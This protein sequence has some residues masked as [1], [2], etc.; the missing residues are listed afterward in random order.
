MMPRSV[1]SDGIQRESAIMHRF[2]VES[3]TESTAEIIDAEA[4]HLTHVLRLK[5]GD[6][7]QLLDGKGTTAQATV[8]SVGRNSAVAAVDSLDHQERPERGLLTVAAAPP[9][10]DRLK[11][12]IEKLT[13]I[14]VDRFIPLQTERGTVTPRETKLDRLQTTVISACKQSGRAWLMTVGQPCSLPDVLADANQSGIFIGHPGSADARCVSRHD[15]RLLLI[16][17]EGGF[18]EDEVRLAIAAGAKTLTWPGTIL[19]TETAAITLAAV[20]LQ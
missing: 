15:N 4:H 12:M 11:W 13:E 16:G 17:P 6:K 14:G 1:F 10:G 3:L 19:R 8:E 2:F 5:P 20:L 9:K 18:T 7:L